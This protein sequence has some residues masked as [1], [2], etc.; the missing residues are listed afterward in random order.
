[1]RHYRLLLLF[2]MFGINISS[3]V[4]Q[5]I[6]WYYPW[7]NM[8]NKLEVAKLDTIPILHNGT[9]YRILKI[10]NFNNYVTNVTV[11]S[12]LTETEIFRLPEMKDYK[13]NIIL[14]VML[15]LN[16][17]TTPNNKIGAQF[18]LVK[19]YGKE[20]CKKQLQSYVLWQS[21]PFLASFC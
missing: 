16:M 8:L 21:T 5:K 1:M 10:D 20:L 2:I 15:P 12:F 19:F 17:E 3:L 9:N 6:T 4:S 18:F 7:N 13:E 14:D 11:S